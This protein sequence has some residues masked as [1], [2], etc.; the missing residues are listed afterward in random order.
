MDAYEFGEVGFALKLFTNS[1]C[2]TECA[3][4]QI[5]YGVSDLLW[6]NYGLSTEDI[7]YVARLPAS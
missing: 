2:I 3:L 6:L 1:C 7:F 4:S 5:H